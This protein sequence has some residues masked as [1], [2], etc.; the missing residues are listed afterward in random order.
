MVEARFEARGVPVGTRM[1]VG[2]PAPFA[3]LFSGRLPNGAAHGGSIAGLLFHELAREL[4]RC[5]RSRPFC[6]CPAFQTYRVRLAT[7]Q[8]CTTSVCL[9]APP[10]GARTFLMR[11]TASIARSG[12][13]LRPSRS[14]L[15]LARTRSAAGLCF[16]P[17]GRRRILAE[18]R[19][20]GASKGSA[21]CRCPYALRN[22]E[23]LRL[24]PFSCAV[25]VR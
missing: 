21:M 22:R 13:A 12:R 10:G 6:T 24:L 20:P 17:P 19:L 1:E 3:V 7:F 2:D 9:I 23:C 25:V 16:A 8:G 4:T 5:T 14:I 15:S 11:P 18:R